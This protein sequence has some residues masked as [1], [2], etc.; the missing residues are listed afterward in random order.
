MH[1]K[2]KVFFYFYFFT[3]LAENVWL[4][5]FQCNTNFE[6][7]VTGFCCIKSLS[8]AQFQITNICVLH[9]IISYH[10]VRCN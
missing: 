2:G 6:E 8:N 9:F 5:K 1:L 10:K 3:V 4:A 7:L